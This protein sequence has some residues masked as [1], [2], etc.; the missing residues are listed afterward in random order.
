[1]VIPW[2]LL[3]D[4]P[5][6]KFQNDI[7]PIFQVYIYIKVQVVTNIKSVIDLNLGPKIAL[8]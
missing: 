5:Y 3:G 6:S 1:M 2:S 8:T 7:S 4:G